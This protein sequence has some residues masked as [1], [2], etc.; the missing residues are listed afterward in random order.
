MLNL[1][2][3]PG[4]QVFIYFLPRGAWCFSGQEVSGL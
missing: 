4:A 3:V 2:S 1:I